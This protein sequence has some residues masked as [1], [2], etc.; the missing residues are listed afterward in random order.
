MDGSF[1][2]LIAGLAGAL[3][4]GASS[5]ATILISALFE[6]K[7]HLNRLAYEAALQDHE[8]ACEL[9]QHGGPMTIAPLTSY[10]HFHVG[11]MKLIHKGNLSTEGLDALRAERDQLFQRHSTSKE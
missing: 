5:V 8:T 1:I 3:I 11:Y 7:R 9:A 10:I 6:N 4:G 2:P